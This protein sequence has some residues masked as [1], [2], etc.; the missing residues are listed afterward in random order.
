MSETSIDARLTEALK[1]AMKA[2]AVGTLDVVRGLKA[3]M[4]EKR[5]SPGFK[6]EVT[7]AL[8]VEV[9]QSYKKQMEKA[10]EEFEK[11]GERGAEMVAKLRFEIDYCAGYLPKGMDA[12]QIRAELAAI[13]ARVGATDVKQAGRVMG[14]FMKAHKGEADGKEVKAI[15]EALLA[16]K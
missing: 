11:V 1:E 4:Q 2:K 3:K 10:L 15:A 9:I 6:G 12:A 14:E 7:D 8:W 13:I 5:T 16:P